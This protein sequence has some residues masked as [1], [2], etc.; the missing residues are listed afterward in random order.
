[1]L[2]IFSHSFFCGQYCTGAE[3]F[4]LVSPVMKFD[5]FFA[6]F[7]HHRFGTLGN[8]QPIY[9]IEYDFDI[10]N[11]SFRIRGNFDEQINR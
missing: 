8:G 6:A 11:E 2:N 7:E 9:L 3:K 1:M 10:F 4:L 5:G